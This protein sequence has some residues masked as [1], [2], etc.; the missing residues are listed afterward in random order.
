MILFDWVID[1]LPGNQHENPTG[2]RE[3]RFVSQEN[4]TRQV[5]HAEVSQLRP[6]VGIVREELANGHDSFVGLTNM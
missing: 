2:T 5:H 4:R 1:E 3:A 6:T